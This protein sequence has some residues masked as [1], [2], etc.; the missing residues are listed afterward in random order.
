VEVS[1]KRG[2]TSDA[3]LVRVVR[4]LRGFLPRNGSSGTPRPLHLAFR[5]FAHPTEGLLLHAFDRAV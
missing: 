4:P 3:T 2:E 5:H 1:E